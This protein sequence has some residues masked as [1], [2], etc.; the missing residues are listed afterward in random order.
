MEQD[1]KL[2]REREIAAQEQ[3]QWRID[4]EEKRE[5]ERREYEEKRERER[6]EYEEKHEVE[7]QEQDDFWKRS[8]MEFQAQLMRSLKSDKEN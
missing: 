6:R 2:Q 8:N 3:A 7:R 4:V 1:R 5:R